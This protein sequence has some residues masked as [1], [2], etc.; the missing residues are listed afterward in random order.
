M[1]AT[2][3]AT[4]TATVGAAVLLLSACG[5]SDDGPTTGAAG[6]S[7]EPRAAATS[8]SPKK[9]T[10]PCV[11]DDERRPEP[12]H[13]IYIPET[14]QWE[15]DSTDTPDAAPPIKHTAPPVQQEEDPTGYPCAN[16]D[17]RAGTLKWIMPDGPW[18]CMS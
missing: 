1:K 4:I 18:V 15:C 6:D 2:V 14:D 16:Q 17:G 10:S 13:Y 9:V 3:R 7:Q 12:G 8:D 5:D 11:T